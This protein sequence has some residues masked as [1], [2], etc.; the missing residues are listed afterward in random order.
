[1][2]EL[3]RLKD[4]FRPRRVRISRVKQFEKTTR[5]TNHRLRC[6]RLKYCDDTQNAYSMLEKPGG[7]EFRT[8]EYSEYDFAYE[9][10]NILTAS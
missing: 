2:S 9:F 8:R 3:S 1:M 7:G 5:K 10:R 6:E 4:D